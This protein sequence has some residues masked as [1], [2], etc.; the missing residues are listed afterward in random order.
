MGLLIFYFALAI[1][2][3]FLCSI[4]EAVLLSMTPSYVS[5]ARKSGSRHGKILDRMKRDVDRPLAAILS[6]NTIAHTVGAAGVGAQAQIVFQSVPMTVISGVLTIL[7]LVFSEIIPKTLGAEYW[8]VLALPSI[9]LIHFL[10]FALWP[11][12]I[13]SRG[14]SQLLTRKDRT[15]SISRAEISAVADLG[16]QEGVIDAEDARM[17]RSVVTFKGIKVSKVYTP[18]P[19]VRLMDAATTVEQVFNSGE[20]MNYSR[21]PILENSE[22]IIGYV[23]KS[24]ILMCAA[25]G[26]GQRTMKELAKEVLIVPE[27]IPLKRALMLFLRNRAHMAAVVDEFGS[28]SGVLALEDV[29]ET[30]IGQEIMD[31]VDEVEDLRELARRSS[32]NSSGMDDGPQG[33]TD[34]STKERREHS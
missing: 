11:L 32:Q 28:F 26:E 22:K 15:P 3:S 24:D 30:L 10:T 13:L 6:L 4:L 29:I 21:Y 2:V 20:P 5:A 16:Q 8:R 31:E 19:V 33:S 1:L 18:R 25:S 23:L 17:L 27:Q 12:V 14:F 7:I 9:Y 34:P